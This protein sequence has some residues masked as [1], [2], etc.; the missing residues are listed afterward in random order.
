MQAHHKLDIL[1]DTIWG[2]ILMVICIIRCKQS[3]S[4]CDVYRFVCNWLISIQYVFACV[5]VMESVSVYL[6]LSYRSTWLCQL[7]CQNVWAIGLQIDTYF[8]LM[9][10]YRSK[11]GVWYKPFTLLPLMDVFTKQSN[12]INHWIDS[13]VDVL[14]LW[15][16]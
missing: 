13:R 4:F 10:K 9:P 2:I 7:W 11:F 3:F 1:L 8:A 6:S 15:N 5:W 16:W 12:Y 14:L